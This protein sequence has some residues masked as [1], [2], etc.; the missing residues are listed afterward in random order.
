MKTFQDFLNEGSLANN[1]EI[2]N[3]PISRTEFPSNNPVGFLKQKTAKLGQVIFKADDFSKE[4]FG[5]GRNDKTIFR[6]ETPLTKNGSMENTSIVKIDIAKGKL[7]FVD[8]EKFEKE[9]I[10]KWE[11]PIKLEFLNI[12]VPKEFGI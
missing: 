9:D 4:E 2:D 6:L 10:I 5:K 8:S 3:I 7:S 11:R 1:V 12:W